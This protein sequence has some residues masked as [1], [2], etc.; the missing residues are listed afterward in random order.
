VRRSRAGRSDAR[1]HG[2][3][4][5]NARLNEKAFVGICYPSK[6]LLLNEK[7]LFI[8]AST[9]KLYTSWLACE[10][11][12]EDFSFHSEYS[13]E[14]STLFLRPM[15]NPLLSEESMGGLLE[16]I[17]GRTID[18][19]VFSRPFLYAARYPSTWVIDDVREAWGAPI[20]DVCFRENYATVTCSESTTLTPS[21]SYY[22]V[23]TVERIEKPSVR[24]R[25]VSVPPG[26][27]GTFDFPIMEPEEFLFHWLRE[28]IPRSPIKKRT[29]RLR[30]TPIPFAR[31]PLRDVLRTM[32]KKS[33]N[34]LA[35]LLLVHSARAL[36][37]S[38]NY[39][40][41]LLVF[42]DALQRIGAGDARLYD[43]SG[44]SRYNLASPAGTVALLK[45]CTKS[46]SIVDSLPIGGKDGTLLGR[47]LPRRVRA[48][49]GSLT[50]VQALAGY[51][52]KEPFSIM[53]N[54]GPT[55]EREMIA[56]IDRIVS[57]P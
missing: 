35:E 34:I 14:G 44:V 54:H 13:V 5:F 27:S 41:A 38:L 37:T 53:I 50:G 10:S 43:G 56:A 12:G 42:N 8:P 52:G 19:I 57:G 4:I 3:K 20:S 26:F 7:R 55:D 23:R 31:T 48:K 21:S 33:S 40:D 18:E 1:R 28:R 22:S 17:G 25:V 32:N 15:G 30:G 45:A 36:G 39:A 9:T 16:E 24:G 11:L 6:K 47:K 51:D 2:L 49:T 29:G 46:R